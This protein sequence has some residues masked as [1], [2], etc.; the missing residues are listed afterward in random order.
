LI[1]TQ[2]SG[3]RTG[4]SEVS[5]Y[6]LPLF[7]VNT[8]I[9]MQP[10]TSIYS[11]DSTQPF[12]IELSFDADRFVSQWVMIT[13]GRGKHARRI[14]V[15]FLYTPVNIPSSESESLSLWNAFRQKK[16]THYILQ[17]MRLRT[18]YTEHD[19]K[20]IN[21]FAMVYRWHLAQSFDS[22]PSDSSSFGYYMYFIFPILFFFSTSFDTNFEQ[23]LLL[24]LIFTIDYMVY[25]VK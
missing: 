17:S 8:S 13:D 6:S 20:S 19:T 23:L 15:D 22:S 16:E 1:R 5:H 11:Y 4:W 7:G 21:K 12:K 10:F 24:L 14:Y 18:Q 3:Y 9:E 25:M 2:H